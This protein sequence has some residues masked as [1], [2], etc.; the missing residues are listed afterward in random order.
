[1]LET[2]LNRSLLALALACL[3]VASSAAGPG[4]RSRAA[5]EGTAAR[6][7]I[8]AGPG[9]RTPLSRWTLR[10]DPAA[11]GLSRGWQHGGFAGRSVAVP[12][13]VDPLAYSG[14]SGTRNYEGSL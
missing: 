6:S 12:N 14:R 3:L 11:R 9:G 1:M 2:L 8:F 4:A 10:S 5:G 13:D 7:P